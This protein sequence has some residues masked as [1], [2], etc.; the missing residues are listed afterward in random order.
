MKP[1]ED[2]YIRPTLHLEAL[3]KIIA[4]LAAYK[5]CGP[6]SHTAI[7]MAEMALGMEMD[8]LQAEL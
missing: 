5:K 4:D 3:S 6:S 1:N 2:I 8:A 7:A